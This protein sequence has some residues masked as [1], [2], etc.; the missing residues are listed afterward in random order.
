MSKRSPITE[1][2]G[3]S[4]DEKSLCQS[5]VWHRPQVGD[6]AFLLNPESHW[7][8]WSMQWHGMGARST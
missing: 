8:E 2:A 6:G 7:E 4:R 5:H 3:A 1:Q